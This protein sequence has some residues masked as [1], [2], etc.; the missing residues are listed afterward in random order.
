[1]VVAVSRSAAHTM[2]TRNEDAIRLLAGLGVEGDAHLGETVQHRSRVARDLL[3][4]KAGVVGVV[5]A[6]G[7][8]RPGDSI[9][10]E[11]PSGEHRPLE[12]I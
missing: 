12:P 11:L 1:M 7:E 9:R 3:V 5:L 10:V 8:V 4:R 6:G 2:A